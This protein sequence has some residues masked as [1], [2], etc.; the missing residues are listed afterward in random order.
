MLDK[1]PF[2]PLFRDLEPAQTD[3]VKSAFEPYFCAAETVIFEQGT[4]A[5]YMYLILEGRV[6]LHYKP[7][8]GPSMVLTR[9]RDGDVFG[10][11]AVIRSPRYTSSITSETPL[12]AIRIH[13]R[14]LWKLVEN[15]P[16][17]GGV[18]I[19]RLAQIVAPRWQNA[20]AQLHAFSD[21]Q[22][23]TREEVVP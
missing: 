4:P 22:L 8:D 15:H 13:G 5:M 3:L 16:Q 2:L 23:K 9:L 17:T 10:W 18:I 20:H 1:L 14:D 6:G 21:L 11:S 19:D 12:D 7:Y